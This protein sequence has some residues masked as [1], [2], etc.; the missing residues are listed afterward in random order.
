MK[1][2]SVS[3]IK[4]GTVIDHIPAGKGLEI[5]R[6]LKLTDAPLTLG[7]HL[8]SR[9]MGFKDLIKVEG[10]T[11]TEEEAGMIALFA[12]EATIN[13]IEDFQTTQKFKAALP[14]RVDTHFVCPNSRCITNHEHVRTRFAVK[15]YGKRVELTCHYCEKSYDL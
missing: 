8:S 10:R 15:R 5:A 13:V 14:D 11:L 6:F 3:A 1:V 2:L 12:P 7:V 9:S 4:N